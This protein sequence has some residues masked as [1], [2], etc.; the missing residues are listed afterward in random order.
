VGAGCVARI[1]AAWIGNVIT[2]SAYNFRRAVESG[3][4]K[5]EDHSN[6]TLAMALKAGAMGVPFMPTRSA[7]GSDLY[8]TNASLKRFNCPFTGEPMTAAAAICPDVAVV[9]VQRAD[10]LGNFHMWGNLGVTKE[11]CMASRHV[12]ITAEE[13]VSS[14]TI[15]SDP[16]RII[17]PGFK[18]SAVV[19]APWGAHPSPVPGYYN[20]DHEAF[21]DYRNQSRSP[22]AFARWRKKWI[23]AVEGP[24]SYPALL[25][26]ERK[27]S[28]VLKHHL[29]SVPVDFGY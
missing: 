8:S 18:V 22:E 28:L 20:R 10:Q 9:H 25:G 27:A 12:L 15:T 5:M 17:I 21:I 14:E 7:L 24:Q 2:G 19:C 13:I 11:A 23:D 3:A 6:L 1:R 4:L 29:P 26:A 16:N